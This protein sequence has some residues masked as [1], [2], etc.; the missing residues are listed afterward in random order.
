[1]ADLEVADLEAVEPPDLQAAQP[2]VADAGA[3]NVG[4][5]H[6][7]ASARDVARDHGLLRAGIEDEVLLGAAVDTASHHDL[8]P[9][10]PNRY[11]PDAALLDRDPRSKG[12]FPLN[13]SR[14]RIS[15][16]AH[17]AFSLTSRLGI[18]LT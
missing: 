14:K 9:L 16:R 18:R 11:A 10:D 3:L 13:E 6:D 8:V 7:A 5:R 15:A 4:D 2:D 1:M 17:A 12:R